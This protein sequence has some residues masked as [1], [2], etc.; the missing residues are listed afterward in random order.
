MYFI[1]HRWHVIVNVSE[2]EH[3]D[4][5]VDFF[6]MWW[7]SIS[8]SFAHV[9]THTQ[10]QYPM[11]ICL[12]WIWWTHNK[13]SHTHYFCM[14]YGG[15]LSIVL[16]CFEREWLVECLPVLI[17]LLF[18]MFIC[19]VAYVNNSVQLFQLQMLHEISRWL[20]YIQWTEKS[21]EG[22]SCGMLDDTIS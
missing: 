5:R 7:K 2:C 4:L 6:I 15:F 11:G 1:Y 12:V 17:M 3:I 19:S 9:R 22:S 21:Y 10:A 18:C 20:F 8:P 16:H 13:Y 14:N